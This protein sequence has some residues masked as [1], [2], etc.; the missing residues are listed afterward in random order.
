MTPGGKRGGH[1]RH[2]ISIFKIVNSCIVGE[3]KEKK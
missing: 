2:L 1:E 3:E